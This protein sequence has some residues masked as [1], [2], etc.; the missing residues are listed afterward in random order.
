LRRLEADGWLLTCSCSQHL[1]RA[2]F[3]QVVAAA[4]ADAG[5]P[6]QLVAEHGHP[7]DHP[8]ALAHPEGEYLKALLL[9]A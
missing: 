1:D 7:P 2:G 9:R 4:A 8:T 3:R 6:L 5:R